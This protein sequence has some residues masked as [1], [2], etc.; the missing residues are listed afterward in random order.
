MPPGDRAERVSR[1]KRASG[2]VFIGTGLLANTPE[3]R[4]WYEASQLPTSYSSIWK[5]PDWRNSPRSR[6]MSAPACRWGHF[7]GR[8]PAESLR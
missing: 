6:V 7:T 5:K 8:G 2:D 1:E 4:S 3:Q